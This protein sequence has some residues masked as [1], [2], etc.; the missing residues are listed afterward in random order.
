M[1]QTAV[2]VF[3]VYIGVTGCGNSVWIAYTYQA[4]V[5]V[6]VLMVFQAVVI[7]TAVYIGVSDCSD[8]VCCVHWCYRLWK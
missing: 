6:T 1:F 7:L 5:I 3:A 4:I 8:S 2:I